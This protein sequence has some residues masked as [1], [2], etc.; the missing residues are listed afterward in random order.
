MKVL[1]FL[2]FFVCIAGAG[3]FAEEDPFGGV[4]LLEVDIETRDREAWQEWVGAFAQAEEIEFLRLRRRKGDGVSRKVA[5]PKVLKLIAAEVA[6]NLEA[7]EVEE[8]EDMFELRIKGFMPKKSAVLW[9]SLS[10][11]VPSRPEG[12]KGHVFLIG[13]RSDDGEFYSGTTVGT[14]EGKQVPALG[15]VLC[16]IGL[17]FGLPGFEPAVEKSPEAG[18]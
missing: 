18:D 5:D 6:E 3:A 14:K 16:D 15:K 9:V 7:S 2:L 17:A 12:L 13:Y 11:T 8:W 10:E 1:H 4:D